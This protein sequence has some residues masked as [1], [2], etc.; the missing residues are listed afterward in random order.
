MKLSALKEMAVR[1]PLGYDFTPEQW[2]Q[3]AA[4]QSNAK[5]VKQIN[6]NKFIKKLDTTSG[7]KYSLWVDGELVSYKNTAPVTIAGKKYVSILFSGTDPNK[8]KKG[9]STEL[10][11]E[12]TLL[13]DDDLFV[14]GA[15]S[16]AGETA[17][18]SFAEYYKKM[19]GDYPRMINRQTG[20]IESYDY[21]KL[22]T[23]PKLGLIYED[24]CFFEAYVD[25]P[26]GRS[27]LNDNVDFSELTPHN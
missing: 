16:A 11:W 26:A 3:E 1:N 5:V 12:L 8:T 6:K 23:K 25:G 19:R 27:W 4:S 14:G 18:A 13:L 10:S 24:C 17:A 15:F 9:Y 21:N 22:M 7:T 2:A 20:E